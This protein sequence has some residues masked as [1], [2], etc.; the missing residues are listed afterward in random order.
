MI[1]LSF[2]CVV[3]PNSVVLLFF[4]YGKLLERDAHKSVISQQRFERNLGVSNYFSTHTLLF[5]FNKYEK[6]C[7]DKSHISARYHAKLVSYK[8]DEYHL[9]F[10][11]VGIESLKSSHP[12]GTT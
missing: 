5:Y 1:A 11:R 4:L 9:I 7:H 10:V 3:I 8:K 12:S 6:N 2:C